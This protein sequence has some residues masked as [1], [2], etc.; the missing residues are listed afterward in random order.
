MGLIESHIDPSVFQS[1]QGSHHLFLCVYVNSIIVTSSSSNE[2]SRVLDFLA[3]KFPIW[4]LGDLKFFLGIEV[5][6]STEGIH[7]CKH[8]V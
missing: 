3:T 2:I 1:K 5:N 7:L 6:K 8:I 4:D